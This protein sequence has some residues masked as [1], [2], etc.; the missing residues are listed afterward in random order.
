[1]A[2]N[3]SSEF[4]AGY[5]GT[6]ILKQLDLVLDPEL[7]ESI[8]KLGFVQSV[9]LRDGQA[10]VMLQLPTSWC[11]VNFAYLMADD[12]R[13]MLLAV[14]G[15]QRVTVRLG[16]HCAAEEIEAAVN[17]GRPFATAFPGT[18][19]A[20]LSALRLTFLRKGFLARQERLL[21]NL[22]AVG[23]S[24]AMIC[25]LR[26]RDMAVRDGIVSAEPAGA[27]PVET[28]PAEVLRH[29]LDRRAELGLDGSSGAPLI[30]D[31]DGTP[32]P[33]E[34]LERHYQD[35]RMIRVALEANGSFCRA[36]LAGRRA[37][38][39]NPPSRAIGGEAHVQP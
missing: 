7:D 5:D 6:V 31:A 28:G 38:G 24:P 39:A 14:E 25:G 29:Y 30:I 18:G 13:H 15:I 8:L 12:V 34:Q 16:D 2:Y 17:D 27:A 1:V 10:V 21:R 3:V 26:L 23:C 20:D 37:R 11:A 36:M 9:Q 19:A 4:P 22:R 33:A 32:L 35:A